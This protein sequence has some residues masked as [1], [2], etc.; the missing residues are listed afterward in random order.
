MMRR[1]KRLA[2]GLLTLCVAIAGIPLHAPAADSE[3]AVSLKPVTYDELGKFIR[4]L[5]G[6]VV[7]VDFWADY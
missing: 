6:Q 3:N 7:I 2:P 1:L 5:K 4:G